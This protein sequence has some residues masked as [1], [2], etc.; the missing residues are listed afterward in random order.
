MRIHML[1]REITDKIA[2]G[3]VVERPASVIKE[4]VENALDAEAR[5]VEVAVWP[6]L[7]DRMEVLDDGI[8]MTPEE[9]RVALL[10]HATSKIACA[11]DLY[12]IATLGFRGEALASIGAVADLQI[13]TRTEDAGLGVQLR[14][15]GGQVV[16]Q[17]EVGM[18]RGTRIVVRGLFEHTPARLKFLRSRPTETGHVLDT[19]LRLALSRPDVGFQLNRQGAPWMH[20]P[21]TPDLRQRAAHLLGWE[22]AER[23][24]PLEGAAGACRLHGLM[25]PAELHRG[26]QRGL[27]FFVNRRPVRDL[28]LLRAIHEAYRGHLPKGR[29]PVAILFLE[30][31]FGD[32]DVN[33]HP[34]KTEVHFA[35][36]QEVRR[37]LVR[38]LA[39]A[40]ER[41]SWSMLTPG[42]GEEAGGAGRG[43][44]PARD[45]PA[46]PP[47]SVDRAPSSPGLLSPGGG[48]RAA[49]PATAGTAGEAPRGP[50]ALPDGA[51]AAWPA[52]EPRGLADARFARPRIL[53]QFLDT[54][55]V[56]EYREQLLLVDQH[57]AHERIAYEALEAAY[58][59]DQVVRQPLLIPP[60]VELPP[61][62]AECVRNAVEGLLGFGLEVEPYGGRSFAV[63]AVPLVLGHADPGR[64]LQDVAEE[65]AE[66]EQ[67]GHLDRLRGHVFA[68]MACHAVV[69]AGRTLEPREMEAL[70][71]GS[72]DKPGRLTCP[73]GRPVVIAWSLQEIQKRFQRA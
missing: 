24:R 73:H 37:F 5:R 1:P 12:R 59:V 15:R 6:A 33:A 30:V 38:Q 49:A 57:A 64:L 61:R 18:A 39:R 9:A 31:P 65:L 46:R 3:E 23:L 22:L 7:T 28:I 20:A 63:K 36:P 45:E 43:E 51:P 71:G 17:R 26:S 58:A 70:L 48:S 62:E 10:R 69:R 34:T 35:R 66:Q 55:L 67:T 25:G 21:A 8:G 27:F 2:A 53:G 32:V 41:E 42:G 54:Y 50:P 52:P 29:V 16:E 40:L 68:R 44:T 4:L 56:C 60:V 72:Y 19:F 11:E 47:A 14:M 13:A